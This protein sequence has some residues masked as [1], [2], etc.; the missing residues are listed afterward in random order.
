MNGLSGLYTHT[1]TLKYLKFF[2]IFIL[3]SGVW[4]GLL[5][6]A[7]AQNE[8]QQ[9]RTGDKE[10]Y[11]A[12]ELQEWN[13]ELRLLKRIPESKVIGKWHKVIQRNLRQD[14]YLDR[15]WQTNYVLAADESIEHV[16]IE[17]DVVGQVALLI[18]RQGAFTNRYHF[19]YNNQLLTELTI[20]AGDKLIERRIL[21]WSFSKQGYRINHIDTLNENNFLKYADHYLYRRNEILI[22][23][24]FADDTIAHIKWFQFTP[25]YV[26]SKENVFYYKPFYFVVNSTNAKKSHAKNTFRIQTFVQENYNDWQD[27]KV[28]KYFY[29]QKNDSVQKQFVLEK[30][31]HP[32]LLYYNNLKLM[33]KIEIFDDNF[34]LAIAERVFDA[35]F[36]KDSVSTIATSIDSSVA[37]PLPF[38]NYQVSE[39]DEY[40]STFLNEKNYEDGLIVKQIFYRGNEE[41]FKTLYS[42][43]ENGFLR[44]NEFYEQD[45]LIRRKMYPYVY[46]EKIS[47]IPLDTQVPSTSTPDSGGTSDS[48]N[49]IKP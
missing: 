7:L 35:L 32:K 9:I 38:K 44:V 47:K 36:K 33:R 12:Y 17:R 14:A 25:N 46:T 11:S 37:L 1:M 20:A 48:T 5:I 41:L 28:E 8:H 13:Y 22:M 34:K 45:T 43:Y 40:N 23:R 3:V 30:G 21:T 31:K 39:Y 4:W 15:R 18:E 24:Y 10:Y 29:N 42:Y 49:D 6:D 16:A 19:F 27:F 26:R 2:K